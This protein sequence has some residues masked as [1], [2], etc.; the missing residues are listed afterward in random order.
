[1]KDHPQT[2]IVL[3]GQ[4]QVAKVDAST[5]LAYVIRNVFME[6]SVKI[7]CAREQ[8]GACAVLV[9]GEWTLSCTKPV[10]QFDGAYIETACSSRETFKRVRAAFLAAGAGQCGYCIPG[11]IVAVAGAVNSSSRPSEQHI[12]SVLKQ[13]LCRCGTQ[14]RVL[15]AVRALLEEDHK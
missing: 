4:E 13:H 8:C 11:M 2:R 10:G 14:N 7:G 12:R 15:Q 5:P 1:M 3:N 6:K 9:D